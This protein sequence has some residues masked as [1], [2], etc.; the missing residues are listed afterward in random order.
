MT[1]FGIYFPFTI[2]NVELTSEQNI[3]PIEHDLTPLGLLAV[4]QFP[5]CALCREISPLTFTT[6]VRTP[7]EG[8]GSSV[9]DELSAAI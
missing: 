8:N 5:R 3:S 7:G 6:R 4:S 2:T 9:S 1:T